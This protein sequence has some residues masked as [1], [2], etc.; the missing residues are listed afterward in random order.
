MEARDGVVARGGFGCGRGDD[1]YL[2]GAFSSFPHRCGLNGDRWFGFK[3]GRTSA[4]LGWVVDFHGKP[5][6]C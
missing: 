6:K 5:A 2:L 1:S 4:R 3:C